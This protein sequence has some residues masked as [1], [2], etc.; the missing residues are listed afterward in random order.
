MGAGADYLATF[1]K[2]LS[3]SQVSTLSY[4]HYRLQQMKSLPHS[5]TPAHSLQ[6]NNGPF[7]SRGGSFVTGGLH[8][9]QGGQGLFAQSTQAEG[10]QCRACES[11]RPLELEGPGP[12]VGKLSTSSS[13]WGRQFK[14]PRI[15]LRF[16]SAHCMAS[17]FYPNALW[18]GHGPIKG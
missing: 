12:R 17:E 6:P 4:H 11:T 3:T 5:T 18:R 2:A 10:M 13:T 1:N 8:A 16:K 9:L 7:Q 14:G 15:I